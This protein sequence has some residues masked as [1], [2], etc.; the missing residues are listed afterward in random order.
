MLLSPQQRKLL[1]IFVF[2]SILG[3]FLDG[4]MQP[5]WMHTYNQAMRVTAWLIPSYGVAALMLYYLNKN[6][7]GAGMTYRLFVSVA[8]M[9]VFQCV[10]EYGKSLLTDTFQT[11]GQCITLDRMIMIAVIVIAFAYGNKALMR[12]VFG[13]KTAA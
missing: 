6:L 12:S 13:S 10:V 1:F 4:M 3:Y 8:V 9:L 5:T 7:K 2:Y 11:V